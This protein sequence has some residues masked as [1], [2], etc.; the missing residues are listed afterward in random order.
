MNGLDAYRMA[1]DVA[2]ATLADL[3]KLSEDQFGHSRA[4]QEHPNALLKK[5]YY[6][7][8]AGENVETAQVEQHNLSSGS[9]IAKGSSSAQNMIQDIGVVVKLECPEQKIL[10]ELVQ[11]AESCKKVLVPLHNSASDLL[12]KVRFAELAKEFKMAV[13]ALEQF[14]NEVRQFSAKNETPGTDIDALKAEIK[15]GERLK[16]EGMGHQDAMKT[17]L[18]QVKA[19][20]ISV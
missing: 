16:I 8:G 7:F 17:K 2:E 13:A 4:I 6:V 18:R 20:L 10:K 1:A 14:L 5:Y 12:P 11:M 9:D 3:L 15:L 19:S